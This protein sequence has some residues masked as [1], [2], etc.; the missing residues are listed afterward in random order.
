MAGAHR[1]PARGQIGLGDLLIALKKLDVR[2]PATISRIA[3]SLGFTGIDTNPVAAVRGA[4]GLQRPPRP[5]RTR[6]T[7]KRSPGFAAPP[8]PEPVIELPKQILRTRLSGPE[9]VSDSA[10]PPAQPGKP[11]RVEPDESPAVQR[12]PLL[13]VRTAKGVLTAAVATRRAGPEPD[14]FRLIEAAVRCEPLK[15]FPRLEYASVH[16]GVQLLLDVSSAMVPFLEDL[17]DLADAIRTV[18]GHQ[19]CE[20]FEFTGNPATAERWT[21]AP[22]PRPWRP[23]PGRPIVLATDFGEGAPPAAQDRARLTEWLAFERRTREAGS[24]V[25]AFVPYR[26]ERWPRTVS[27]R[28]ALIH[29]DPR[30]RASHVRRLLGEGLKVAP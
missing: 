11:K 18:V 16:Q 19:G 10:M 3:A 25:V 9:P 12:A 14:I 23:Q 8:T 24:P 2:D 4:T 7:P 13:P 20:V 30:T 5:R 22:Q 28:V 15:D 27:R 17:D 21:A 6:P 29:W 1:D 26:R